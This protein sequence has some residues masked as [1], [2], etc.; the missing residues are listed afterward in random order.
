LDSTWSLLASPGVEGIS[1]GTSSQK[2]GWDDGGQTSAGGLS[3]AFCLTCLQGND[4]TLTLEL[5]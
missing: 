1:S 4:F 3:G 5:V 2:L